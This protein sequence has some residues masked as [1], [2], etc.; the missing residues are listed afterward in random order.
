MS[1]EIQ[2]VGEIASLAK[3]IMETCKK[4]PLTALE[5]FEQRINVE[6][7]CTEIIQQIEEAEKKGDKDTARKLFH[8]FVDATLVLHS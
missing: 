5:D 4:K 1:G 8:D 7:Q 3:L 6:E 2:A